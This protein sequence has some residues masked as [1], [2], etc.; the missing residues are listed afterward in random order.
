LAAAKQDLAL[1][2]GPVATQLDIGRDSDSSPDYAQADYD[3]FYLYGRALSEAEIQHAVS[4][5]TTAAE[6]APVPLADG[7]QQ[8]DWWNDAWPFRCRVAIPAGETQQARTVYRLPL[9][10]QADL[11]AL[12]IPGEIDPASVRVVDRDV[13]SGDSAP[14]ARLLPAAV[15]GETIAWQM[16][17]G[18]ASRARQVD[19]YFGVA[20]LDAGVPLFLKTRRSA[21]PPAEAAKLQVPDYAADTYGQ[22]WNFDRDGDFA[23]ID[24]WG[25]RPEFLR[26]RQVRG[27]LLSF[28]VT[29][30]PYF[31]WGNMWSDTGRTHRPVAI[32]LQQYPLLLM[33]V[34]QSCR[35]AEWELYG[36]NDSPALLKYKFP[37]EGPAWQVIRVDLVNT[38]RW[39]GVLKAL[40]IDPTSHVADAH[41]DI[42]WIRLTNEYLV[43]RQPTEAWHAAA[44]PA[45]T[46]DVQVERSPATCGSRQTV[47]VRA[48][49]AQAQPVAGQPLTLRLST[50]DG[51]TLEASPA[52]PS[53]AIGPTGRRAITDRNG[54]VRATLVDSRRAG[55]DADV[56]RAAVDFAALQS[57]PIAVTT[58]PAAADHYRITPANPA[59]LGERRFPLPITVQLVDEFGNAVAV[60]GRRV[61]LAVTP[62]AR[63]DPLE[64]TTDAQGRAAATLDVN[65]DRAWTVTIDGKDAA[66]LRVRPATYSVALE[67]PRRGPI[68]LLPNGYFA[69][70]GR[71]PF[72]PL[73]GFYANWVQLETPNGEWGTIK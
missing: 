68:R 73:G 43:R 59:T 51:G 5:V 38:A 26:N 22:A 39:G 54:I 61:K 46:L 71:R 58:R 2:V 63:L 1:D 55:A 64:L 52:Q 56:V 45:A 40:R 28:D 33:R 21:W 42:D 31:I 20:Q 47:T 67:Q 25:N 48:L 65:A 7:K 19:V 69:G 18:P 37:V 13:P 66:G 44:H 53:L 35:N 8:G 23:G 14:V 17:P 6:P 50:D 3:E 15:D 11:S 29:K 72:V 16:P 41:V 30:D 27:G 49:D 57:A 34:R 60:A 62:G 32:D 36:R 10:L 24:A 12:G 4:L 9:D 70:E